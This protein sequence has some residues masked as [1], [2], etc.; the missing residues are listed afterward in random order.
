VTAKDT[1]G[2]AIPTF[3][4]SYTF[5]L[6]AGTSQSWTEG[7]GVDYKTTITWTATAYAE[8]DVN[9]DNNS[10]TEITKVTR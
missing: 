4:R 10:V 7:F 9:P 2:T 6:V 3:P 1:N 8:F 5:S